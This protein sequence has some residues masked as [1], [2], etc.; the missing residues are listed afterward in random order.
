[1]GSSYPLSLAKTG[2]IIT[3]SYINDICQVPSY[4]CL[5]IRLIQNRD[6]LKKLI[7]IWLFWLDY[8]VYFV[9]ISMWD[10]LLQFNDDP[11]KLNA[12]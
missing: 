10:V 7:V 9:K 12:S 5:M 1:M 2:T 6:E 3:P 4:V 11:G 8:L